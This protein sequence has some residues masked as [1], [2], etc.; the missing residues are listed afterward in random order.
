[1]SL[2][3]ID[4]LKGQGFHF[5]DRGFSGKVT[6]PADPRTLDWSKDTLDWPKHSPFKVEGGVQLTLVW[7]STNRPPQGRRAI[8]TGLEFQEFL[9]SNH[10]FVI[11]SYQRN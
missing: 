2:E 7:S 1:M 6:T 8:D 4:E 11:F 3:C 9:L 5:V 10:L